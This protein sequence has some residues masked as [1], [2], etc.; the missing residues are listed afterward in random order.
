L[1]TW[2]IERPIAHR[3][4]HGGGVVENSRAAFERAAQ[5]RFPIEC[6]VRLTGDGEI[7]VFHDNILDRLTGRSGKVRTTSLKEMQ[8]LAL[9]GSDQCPLSFQELLELVN[10]RVP[11]L[12]ELKVDDFTTK[13]E[14]QVLKGLKDYAGEVAL[15][16][17]NPFS[18]FFLKK[19]SPYP[20][21]YLS[22]DFKGEPIG[23]ATKLLLR[24]LFFSPFVRPDFVG[25]QWDL[26][27]ER[28]PQFMHQQLSI[29]L[30][31]WT[32]RTKNQQ[33]VV[34]PYCNNIIFEGFDPYQDETW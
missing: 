18:V 22:G 26:I 7:V 15:Q 6:D 4:L 33:K 16:S 3:G 27:E 28:A 20:V 2:Y 14:R 9:L 24:Q 23:K 21:G 17:F 29:P 10:G 5:S 1:S 8:Q 25:Y 32:I 13:T 12:I 31:A 34:E 30:L 11:L 19:R